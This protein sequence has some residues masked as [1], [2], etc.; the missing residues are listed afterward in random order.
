VEDWLGGGRQ[1]E[2]RGDEDESWKERGA[3]FRGQS[4]GSSQTSSER[5]PAVPTEIDYTLNVF[6][7]TYAVA[8]GA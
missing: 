7:I 3:G 5:G 6:L 4:D 8:G 1:R 2:E